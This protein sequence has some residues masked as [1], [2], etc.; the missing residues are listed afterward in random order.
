MVTVTD[1]NEEPSFKDGYRDM[2][3]EYADTWDLGYVMRSR[4]DVQ[5]YHRNVMRD[6]EGLKRDVLQSDRV[7]HTIEKV[8]AMQSM[9]Y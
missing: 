4:G 9:L 2:L 3:Y 7:Q 8:P 6:Y 1:Q 5:L